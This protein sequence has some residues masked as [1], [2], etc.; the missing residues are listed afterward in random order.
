MNQNHKRTLEYFERVN[1]LSKEIDFPGYELTTELYLNLC[2]KY[3]DQKI[4][5]KKIQDILKE[6][7]NVGYTT[8]FH[9]YELFREKVYLE[10]AHDVIQE[11][12]KPMS[13]EFKQKF[14]DYPIPNQ[15]M[16][17]YGRVVS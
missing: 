9:L 14:M 10:S 2:Y 16:K 4:D 15:I 3:F 8:N 12:I 11:M 17:E 6:T 5:L 7:E 13:D 1:K